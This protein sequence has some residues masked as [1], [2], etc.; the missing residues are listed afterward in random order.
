MADAPSHSFEYLDDIS[1]FRAPD[2]FV[3]VLGG[4][5]RRKADLLRALAIGLKFPDYFGWNWDAL[6]ECM[7]D[8][9]WLPDPGGVVLAH[10]QLPLDDDQQRRTYVD[11]LKGALVAHEGSLRVIFPKATRA[12]LDDSE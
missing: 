9:S 5:L 6:D 10:K 11:I 1:G 12:W 4:R 2:S 7:R 8:L 3:A